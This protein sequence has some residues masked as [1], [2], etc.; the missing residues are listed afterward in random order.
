MPDSA[1]NLLMA[2]S[3]E[4][5]ASIQLALEPHFDDFYIHRVDTKDA[6]S[7]ALAEKQWSLLFS[8]VNLADF[9][10]TELPELFNKQDRKSVV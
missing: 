2:S 5:R 8:E 4:T 3:S 6:L 9:S 10:A 7:Q 1:L